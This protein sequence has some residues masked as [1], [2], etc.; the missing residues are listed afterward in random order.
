LLG[1]TPVSFILLYFA[2]ILA[3]A[4]AGAKL[5]DLMKKIQPAIPLAGF[6]IITLLVWQIVF[7]QPDSRLHMTL[8][9]VST[10]GNSGHAL[11]IVTP[12]G[13][14][15]LIDGGPTTS[16]LSDALGRR[17][18]WND[19]DFDWLVVAANGEDELAALPRMIERFPPDNVLWAGAT[20]GNTRS[21]N[22]W[23]ATSAKRL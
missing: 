22:L 16:L 17:M 21:R 8:L 7:T 12:T 10:L 1:D 14:R 4:F 2:A 3:I 11:L 15:V 20:H 6:F 18:P 9:N 19:H 23:K 5:K 13:R